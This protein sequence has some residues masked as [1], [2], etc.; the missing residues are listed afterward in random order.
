[1]RLT[2]PHLESLRAIETGNAK[3]SHLELQ[4]LEAKGLIDSEHKLTTRGLSALR[5]R[6]DVPKPF[7]P[8]DYGGT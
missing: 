3:P 8:N 4:W 5:Q 6:R 1:M 2:A 7:D